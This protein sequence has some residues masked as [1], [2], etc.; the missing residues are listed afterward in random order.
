MSSNYELQ[1]LSNLVEAWPMTYDD[2]AL[3]QAREYLDSKHATLGEEYPYMLER[4]DDY[5]SAWLSL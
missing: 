5:N 4:G 3:S 2:N 1:I